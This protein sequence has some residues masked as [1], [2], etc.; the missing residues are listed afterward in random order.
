MPNITSLANSTALTI[1][2]KNIPNVS[3]LVKKTDHN[4]KIGE[5]EKNY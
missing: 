2:K 3:K 4:T 5:T 1:V